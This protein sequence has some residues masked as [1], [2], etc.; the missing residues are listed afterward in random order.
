MSVILSEP[1][2]NLSFIGVEA[3]RNLS[4]RVPLAGQ[5]LDL[6]LQLLPFWSYRSHLIDVAR[7]D[8]LSAS[9]SCATRAGAGISEQ[10]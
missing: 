3:A 8:T 6:P 2:L 5:P 9:S 4:T 10:P 7:Q 1:A